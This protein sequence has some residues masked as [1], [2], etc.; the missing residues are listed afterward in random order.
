M[1]VDEF[2]SEYERNKK[3]YKS[4]DKDLQRRLDNLER[5][6]DS[7][8]SALEQLETIENIIEDNVIAADVENKIFDTTVGLTHILDMLENRKLELED[9]FIS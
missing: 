8:S 6:M 1:L 5:I 4:M 2:A 7:I 3:S 9:E